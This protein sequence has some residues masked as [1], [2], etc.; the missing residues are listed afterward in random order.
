MSKL[1]VGVNPPMLRISKAV[2][3]FTRLDGILWQLTAFKKDRLL[4]FP[5]YY[6]A[7]IFSYK[8]REET[9]MS[10][11]KPRIMRHFDITYVKNGIPKRFIIHERL[12]TYTILHLDFEIIINNDLRD[13]YYYKNLN[14]YILINNERKP[15]T[16]LRIETVI[17]KIDLE[18]TEAMISLIQRR[19]GENRIPTVRMEEESSEMSESSSESS[20]DSSSE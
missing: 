2:M 19:P 10:S 18:E 12:D 16:F 1:P 13:G 7:I 8:E 11:Y 6:S 14:S 17:R 9:R 3:Q 20:S 5:N 15:I 4:R